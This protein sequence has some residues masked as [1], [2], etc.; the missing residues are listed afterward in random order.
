MSKKIN[1]N[2]KVN[3]G[4]TSLVYCEEAYAQDLYNAIIGYESVTKDVNKG[5]ILKVLE[6][7]IKNDSEIY[8]LTEK[9]LIFSIAIKK[10]KVFLKIMDS[11]EKGF[12]EWVKLGNSKEWLKENP[13]FIYVEDEQEFKASLLKAH[14][15]KFAKNL[16]DQIKTPTAAYL[17]KITG[18][19]QGG[20]FAEIHGIK[21]FMPGS[22]AAAN[23][24]VNF[25][26]YIG[27]EI[28]VMIE[29]YIES[30][31]LFIVS[32]KKYI[33][34]ILPFKLDE[35]E[36]YS[37]LTGIITGS[38]KHGIFVEFDQIFTGLL[39]ISEM[40]D[41]TLEKHTARFYKPGDSITVWLKDIKD[42]KLILS[43]IDPNIKI[44]INKEIKE[45]IEGK[46]FNGIITG[47]KEFGVFVDFEDYTGL[48]TIKELKKDNVTVELNDIVQVS[49][50]RVE[51]ET[52]KIYLA[53]KK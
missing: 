4:D 30:S 41:N 18:K 25:G 48:I 35:L 21:C 14:K 26:D 46:S 7:L 50:R 16:K 40:N 42:S 33:D 44:N 20:F 24:I 37:Q 15:V 45:L 5:E 10:E 34:Y 1:T 39:H 22:L 13:Q 49:V 8:A 32:Y 12:I 23:K 9:G 3:T 17:A 6:F 52:G 28:Q 47:I 36:K 27:K 31:D 29:D 51:E 19:N 38:S 43:D 2:V 11:D 53:I